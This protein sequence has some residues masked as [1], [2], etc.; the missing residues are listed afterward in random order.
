MDRLPASIAVTEE[1]A[2]ASPVRIALRSVAALGLVALVALIAYSISH[3]VHLTSVSM[4]FVPVVL[5][6]AIFWGMIPALVATGAAVI[7]GSF[8]FY[9][10]IFS[11]HVDDPQELIDLVVFTCVAVVSSQLADMARRAIHAARQRAIMMRSLLLFSR[12]IGDIVDVADIPGVLA[13]EIGQRTGRATAIFLP[14]E[15]GLREMARHGGFAGVDPATIAAAAWSRAGAVADRDHTG[16][17]AADG[18]IVLR[19]GRQPVGV[20]VLSSAPGAPLDRIMLAALMEQ[21]VAALA[22]MRVAAALEETRLAAK[23]E[24]LREAIIGSI[25]HDLKT[26]L[27]SILGAATTLER[28]GARCDEATRTEL[29][30]SIRTGAERLERHIGRM[31]DLT[32]IRAGQLAPHLEPVDVADVVDAALRLARGSLSGRP[33]EAH[34]EE[35]LPMVRTDPILIEQALVNVLENAGKY[36][37]PG[38]LIRIATTTDGQWVTVSVT[39]AGIGLAGG[40]TEWIFAPFYRADAV[41]GH[42]AGTGL[43]LMVSRAFVEAAGGRIWAESAGPGT[44]A[45]F[46]IALPCVETLDNS[47]KKSAA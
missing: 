34:A 19:D 46:R 25:S 22:H 15:G 3:V 44:G 1:P 41:S 8:F 38:S 42:V 5:A 11:L 43:G 29:L 10:P 6:A 27:A 12:R 14:Q 7:A 30:S 40:E 4:V 31:F 13:L 36:S 24:D 37:P 21:A 47:E 26:P 23:A 20:A 45:V 16:A 35:D 39:D 17:Q 32:R 9:H 33:V 28:F 18:S 2:E